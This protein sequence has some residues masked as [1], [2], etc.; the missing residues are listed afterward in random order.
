METLLIGVIREKMVQL[1]K[2]EHKDIFEGG[3][4]PLSTF[5]SKIKVGYALGCYGRKTRHD[6][7]ALREIR[8]QF[9]HT[10]EKM[11]IDASMDKL[12]GFHC[13]QGDVGT[14]TARQLLAEITNRLAL[15]LIWKIG[16][17]E[18]KGIQQDTEYKRLI[19]HLD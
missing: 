18:K 3:N 17:P 6:L 12:K 8:N 5:S 9:A 19:R 15:F 14:L 10:V 13:I 4:A 2:T 11:D 1:N 16:S 7:D